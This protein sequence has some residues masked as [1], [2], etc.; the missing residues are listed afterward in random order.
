[1]ETVIKCMVCK[2]PFVVE[3]VLDTEAIV[4]GQ[5]NELLSGVFDGDRPAFYALYTLKITTSIAAEMDEDNLKPD[6]HL[7]DYQ[8]LDW[9]KARCMCD[10]GERRGAE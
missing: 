3:D 5:C 8:K 4:C 6:F 10:R 1:M 9:A 7:G 2:F